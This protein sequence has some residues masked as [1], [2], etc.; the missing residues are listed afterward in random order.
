MAPT[1]ACSFGELFDVR[2]T[3]RV[4]IR[5]CWYGLSPHSPIVTVYYLSRDVR[6]GF[7]GDGVLSTPAIGEHPVCVTLRPTSVGKFFDALAC[8]RVSPDEYCPRVE[9]TDDFPH[10]DILL[11][12]GECDDGGSARFAV[13]FT[14]SQGRYYAPWGAHV[15]DA[16]WSIPGEEIGRALMRIRRAL[17]RPMLERLMRAA[18]ERGGAD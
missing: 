17:K 14:R 8:A 12:T 2:S 13:L 3:R 11:S 5:D 18:N 15:A 1:P 16:E 10:I 4:R 7:G 6:G 9:W